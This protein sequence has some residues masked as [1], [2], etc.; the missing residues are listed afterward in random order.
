MSNRRARAW[1]WTLN[2]YTE[3]EIEHIQA[4]DA[5]FIGYGKEVGDSG[6]PHLQGFVQWNNAKTLSASKTLLGNRVHLE[7]A[8]GRPDQAWA[9]C[10]KD[11]DVWFSGREPLTPAQQGQL[12]AEAEKTRWERMLTLARNGELVTLSSE[13]PK[14]YI[15]YKRTFEQ[16][17]KEH[18][19]APSALPVL[20]NYWIYGPT[21]SGKSSGV[22]A[23]SDSLFVKDLNKWWDGYNGEHDVLIDDMDPDSAKYMVKKMKNWVDHY[24]FPAEKKGGSM[25]IRPKRIF[26]TSNYPLDEVFQG[27]DLDAM[28]RRFKI[29]FHLEGELNLTD[30]DE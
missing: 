16:I 9:Y 15:Q 20:E 3:S 12:G 22:R 23:N 5:K 19:E 30:L 29:I 14:A 17:S 7:K 18:E 13:E 2:N 10:Q 25:V 28:R 4:V 26:V 1:V 8:A 21:G 24:P 11:G 6:T 27:R